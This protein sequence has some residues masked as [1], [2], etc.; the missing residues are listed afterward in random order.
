MKSLLSAK[1]RKLHPQGQVRSL[2]RI[3][4]R[5]QAKADWLHDGPDGHGWHDG[6]D[7]SAQIAELNAK[8]RAALDELL[9]IVRE[10]PDAGW[11]LPQRRAAGVGR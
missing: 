3:A 2:H 9:A 1:N 11:T 7:H 8:A 4:V 5:A 10:N 6:Q